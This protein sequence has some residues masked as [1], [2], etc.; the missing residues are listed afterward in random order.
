MKM[1]IVENL[2]ER[3]EEANIKYHCSKAIFSDKILKFNYAI[4][5]SGIWVLSKNKT[6]KKF[7]KI[8]IV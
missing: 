5:I 1:K 7:F 8:K 2:M 3:S 6:L 4:S